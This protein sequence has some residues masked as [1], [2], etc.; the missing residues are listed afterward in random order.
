MRLQ[1]AVFSVEDA[2]VGREDVNKVLSI[3]KMEGVWLYAVTAMERA[4]AEA[5]LAEAGAAEFFRGVLTER[6][7]KCPLDGAAI[8][9]KAMR[10]LQ[11][12]PRDTVVF[13]GRLA[14]LRGAKAAGLRVA[15]VAGAAEA[16]E[17]AAMRAEADEIVERYADFLA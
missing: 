6:E 1:S 7:T 10:R 3:L 4:E 2:V 14:A 8:Y 15:A 5:A 16:D 9:E 17:W 12:T 11:S 13:T